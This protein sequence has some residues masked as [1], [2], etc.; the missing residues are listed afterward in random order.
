VLLPLYAH[1]SH[2]FWTGQP[3]AYPAVQKSGAAA[4]AAPRVPIA[5]L[6]SCDNSGT[7]AVAPNNC[8]SVVSRLER[9]FVR[10]G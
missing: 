5:A 10:Y 6:R 1:F 2:P 4:L 8:R 9:L 7:R 3:L